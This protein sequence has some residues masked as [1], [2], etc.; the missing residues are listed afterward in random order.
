V[1]LDNIIAAKIKVMRLGCTTSYEHISFESWNLAHEREIH[2]HKISYG[3]SS[4]EII[5]LYDA[6]IT[7]KSQ[8]Q[9]SK[10]LDCHCLSFF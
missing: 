5:H 2:E 3:T 1:T 6:F 9:Y 7:T 10:L 4:W 8:K